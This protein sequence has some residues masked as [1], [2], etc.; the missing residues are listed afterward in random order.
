MNWMR[1]TL[2]VL[3]GGTVSSLTDWLFMGDLLY[4]KFNKYPEIWRHIGGKGESAAIA[5][6]TPLPFLTCG[7]FVWLCVWLNLR[8][9]TQVLEL[10]FAIWLIAA[11]PLL[12]VTGLFMKLQAAI[13]TS[14]SA[15]WLVKLLVAAAAAVWILR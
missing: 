6:S 2:A 13:V 10:A 3:A 12:I 11:L 5:W 15:G 8:S 7:I 14:Y 9:A 1:F 4:R